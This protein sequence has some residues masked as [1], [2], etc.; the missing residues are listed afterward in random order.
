[1]Q[2]TSFF[3]EYS[4]LKQMRFLDNVVTYMLITLAPLLS[5]ETFQHIW[6]ICVLHEKVHIHIEHM[7]K[8]HFDSLVWCHTYC[9]V[10]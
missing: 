9:D 5:K 6:S 10:S 2:V 8:E 7:Q 3:S 1:M 4:I